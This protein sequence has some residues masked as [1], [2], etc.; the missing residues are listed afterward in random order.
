MRR[1]QRWM[2]L[3]LLAPLSLENA[4]LSVNGI[5]SRALLFES[6]EEWEWSMSMSAVIGVGESEGQQAWWCRGRLV[7]YPLLLCHV[8]HLL[9]GLFFVVFAI[10]SS[11]RLWLLASSRLGG[12][13]RGR[14]RSQRLGCC[15]SHRRNY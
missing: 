1:K 10:G 15:L 8:V 4:N 3:L 12:Q 11:Y 6:S 13:R 14:C 7:V 5:P 2:W 9:D